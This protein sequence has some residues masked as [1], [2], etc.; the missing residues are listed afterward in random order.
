MKVALLV[1]V[2]AAGSGAASGQSNA[3]SAWRP[4]TFG[5]FPSPGTSPGGDFGK[6]CPRPNSLTAVPQVIIELPPP[7]LVNRLG[8][9]SIDPELVVHP[10]PRN[11]GAQPPAIAVAQNQFPGLALLPI[12]GQT[13]KPAVKPI[14]ITWPNLK[15]EPIPTGCPQCSFAPANV[16][17]PTSSPSA[18]K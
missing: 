10:P 7:R 3:G 9:M 13:P 16:G 12:D 18:Q 5:K 2:L 14:P 8:D 11:L 17:S 15:M 6:F 4:E 1:I